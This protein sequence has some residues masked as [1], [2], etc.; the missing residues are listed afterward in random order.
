MPRVRTR[1]ISTGLKADF[2]PMKKN[3]DLTEDLFNLF[4]SWLD[5]DR[6]V[7]GKK[8]EAIRHELIRKFNGRQCRVSEELA[9]QTFDRVIRRL[10]AIIDSYQGDPSAY[11]YASARSV[12][13]DHLEK[14]WSPL[15]EDLPDKTPLRDDDQEERRSECQDMCVSQLAPDD[16]TLVLQYYR[17]DKQAKIDH[18]R[19]LAE[20]L[21]IEIET[22]RTRMHRLRSQLR[23][24]VQEC[25]EQ[26]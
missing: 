10:P 8:Y 6:D 18:R 21:G 11:I 1:F 16:R 15:P 7:A 25:L 3:R 4:L 2:P 20:A 24:C 17:E 13:F 9:D 19:R 26:A 22:M 5:P 23:R 14:G 12:F